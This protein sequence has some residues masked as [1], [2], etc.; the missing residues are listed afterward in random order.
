ML[1]LDDRRSV[2]CQFLSFVSPANFGC[3]ILVG[4]RYAYVQVSAPLTGCRENHKNDKC[5]HQATVS[6]S[7]LVSLL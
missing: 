4:V 2:F 7:C 3:I 1:H 5:R 6:S